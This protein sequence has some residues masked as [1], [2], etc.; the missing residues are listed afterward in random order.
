MNSLALVNYFFRTRKFQ[1]LLIWFT[2]V[3]SAASFYIMNGFIDSLKERLYYSAR[4]ISSGDIKIQSF[5]E[6]K[7]D[8]IQFLLLTG[9]TKVSEREHIVN[10]FQLNTDLKLF[11]ISIKAGGVGLNLT[12]ANYIV[13]MDPWWNPF[14]EKQAIARAHR[15]G[16][17]RSVHVMR[18]ITKNSIEQK[19]LTIQKNKMNISEELLEMDQIPDW[20]SDHIS[21]LIE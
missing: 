3:I 14:T 12:A 16:Q 18:F 8:K 9:D 20:L 7:S 2:V 13:I 1:L 19:I 15:M 21:E 5:Q 4:N 17:S 11:L 10:Q 6:L